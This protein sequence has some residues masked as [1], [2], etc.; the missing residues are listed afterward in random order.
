MQGLGRFRPFSPVK[1]RAGVPLVIAALSLSSIRLPA[2][3]VLVLTGD[4][5]IE[6]AAVRLDGGHLVL[7][8]DSAGTRTERLPLGEALLLRFRRDPR[9]RP[10]CAWLCLRD[11]RRLRGER[12]ESRPEGIALVGLD[13]GGEAVPPDRVEAVFL[14]AAEPILERP[15]AGARILSRSGETLSAPSVEIDAEGAVVDIDPTADPVRIPW[16]RLRGIVWPARQDAVGAPGTRGAIAELRSGE[17]L[18]GEIVSLDGERLVLAS[19]GSVRAV[20]TPLG[21]P[22]GTV[23]YTLAV[24]ETVT[25]WIAG[26]RGAYLEDGLPPPPP[27]GSRPAYRL[28]RNVLGG[29]LAVGRRTFARGI[30]LRGPASL[31]ISAP[32]GARWLLLGFGADAG[33]APFARVGIE[34]L[35]RGEPRWRR[36]GLAPGTEVER[37]AI[38]L[39]DGGPIA[40]RIF[41][42]SGEDPTGCLGDIV[43]ALFIE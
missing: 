14:D 28:G 1:D 35:V 36:E 25:V 20:S 42:S 38:P 21:P 3:E 31:E 26:R 16:A 41:P 2:A 34:V 40:L 24:R 10:P 17:R 32:A 29:R 23:D 19:G 27:D 43:D 12:I 5:A 8:L 11:G 30:G 9:D 15:A 37:A 7:L 4:R 33:A 18:T 39:K 13:G 22:E 6:A